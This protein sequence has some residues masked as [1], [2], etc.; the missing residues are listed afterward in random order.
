[1]DLCA[2]ACL[3]YNHNVAFFP[4]HFTEGELEAEALPTWEPPEG[5][6]GWGRISRLPMCKY[7]APHFNIL[8]SF[9]NF[10]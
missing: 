4:P 7:H 6:G 10:L 3:F 1:M 2:G 8:K 5:E 9:E